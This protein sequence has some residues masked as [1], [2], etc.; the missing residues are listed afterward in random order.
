MPIPTRCSHFVTL[1]RVTVISVLGVVIW[2]PSACAEGAIIPPFGMHWGQSTDSVL[3]VL[4]KSKS[5]VDSRKSEDGIET[6][7]VE[8]LP[9]ASLQR[10]LVR[11]RKARLIEVELQYQNG[12]WTSRQYRQFMAEARRKIETKLGGGSLIARNQSAF[13]N[14]ITQT[15]IGY[16]W[17]KPSSL[18]QLFYFSASDGRETYQTVSLHYK[19]I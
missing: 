15:V 11:F 13:E 5:R 7:T 19:A 9:Q 3:E 8:N 14:D 4:K 2:S 12:D 17:E 10:M 6:W 18:L 1:L 16:E